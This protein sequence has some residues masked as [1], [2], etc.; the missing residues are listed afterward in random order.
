MT[1]KE[2]HEMIRRTAAFNPRRFGRYDYAAS[3]N[4]CDKD[5]KARVYNALGDAWLWGT[6]G[7][8]RAH[9][10]GLPTGSLKKW[11]NNYHTK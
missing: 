10:T 9:G 1:E 6:C 3:F 7:L 5:E 4:F 2:N 11:N 8:R